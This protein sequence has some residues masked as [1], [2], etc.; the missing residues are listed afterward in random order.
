MSKLDPNNLPKFGEPKTHPFCKDC[1]NFIPAD[2]SPERPPACKKFPMI[3]LVM[4]EK[5]FIPCHAVRT[6]DAPC[7]EDGKMFEAITN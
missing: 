4:G 6:P 3:D 1:K 7:G 2:V 5:F